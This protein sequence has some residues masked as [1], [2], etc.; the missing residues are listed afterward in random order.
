M[1]MEEVGCP[2]AAATM[3]AVLADALPYLACPH[4]RGGFTLDERTLRCTAGHAFDL[5]RQGYVNLVARPQRG[6]A[7]DT[8]A[9]VQARERFLGAGHYAGLAERVALRAAA[10]LNGG[11]AGC[12]ADVGAGTGYHLRAVL[13]RSPDRVG[14]ALDASRYALRRAARAHPRAGAVGCDAWRPYPLC[15][16]SAALLLDVFAPRD[17]AEF[18]RVLNPDGRLLVVTPT[19]RHLRELVPALGL[20]TVDVD[21]E[22][23]LAGKLDPY[24]VPEV[25]ET[26]ELELALSHADVEA[27][28]AMGPS[29]WHTEPDTLVRRV[30]VLPEPAPVTMSVTVST[31]RPRA[32]SRTPS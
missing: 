24:F 11:V 5:A 7:G 13:D 27:L 1:I 31:Y 2:S 14:L 10:V 6:P 28:A 3:G 4:C 21:K 29:A 15:D 17:G 20:L 25:T 30:A 8:L 32:S 9:M 19:P 23:R 12:V 26:Y 18:H 16:G 22:R